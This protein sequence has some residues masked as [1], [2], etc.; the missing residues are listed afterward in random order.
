PRR[1]R[2]SP[3]RPGPR[4]LGRTA[5]PRYWSA[6]PPAAR[7]GGSRAEAGTSAPPSERAPHGPGSRDT[8]GPAAPAAAGAARDRRQR[9]IAAVAAGDHDRSGRPGSWTATPRR[10]RAARPAP[11]D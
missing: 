10:D 5:A 6:T 9:P 2:G 4:R 1:R 3:G 11:S 7:A 8:G